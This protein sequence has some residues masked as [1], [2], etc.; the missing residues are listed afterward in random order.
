MPASASRWSSRTR[1]PAPLGGDV[2]QAGKVGEPFDAERIAGGDDEP[3]LA[4]DEPD[5]TDRP[6]G[7][8]VPIHGSVLAGVR[9]EQVAAGEA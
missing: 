4:M 2:A 5:D 3:L 6:S 7:Q 8:H 1:V 9:V